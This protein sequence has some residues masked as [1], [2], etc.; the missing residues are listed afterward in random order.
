MGDGKMG[1]GK[2]LGAMD[3]ELK[4]SALAPVTWGFEVANVIRNQPIAAN[5]YFK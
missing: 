3:D 2:I 1:D 5:I 4:T